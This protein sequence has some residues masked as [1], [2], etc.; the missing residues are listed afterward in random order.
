[1]AGAHYKTKIKLQT[2]HETNQIVIW[3]DLNVCWI[4][5]RTNWVSN[6]LY[7][8]TN[9][10]RWIERVG[11]PKLIETNSTDTEMELPMHVTRPV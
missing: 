6:Q 11:Q 1:M 2:F 9:W 8:I 4:M 10:G 7:N 3:V 5:R